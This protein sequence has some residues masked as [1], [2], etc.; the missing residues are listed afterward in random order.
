MLLLPE[1][2]LGLQVVDQEGAGVERGAPVRRRREHPDDRLADPQA[3][4]TVAHDGPL[5]PETPAGLLHHGLDAALGHAGVMLQF[6]RLQ[7]AVVVA[8]QTEKTGL[9]A[10]PRAS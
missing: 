4:D 8:H 6:E 5:Q 2:R 9:G 1:R 3:P 10:D 7:A